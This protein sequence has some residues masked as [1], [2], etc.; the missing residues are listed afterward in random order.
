MARTWSRSLS[1][2]WPPR[3]S[4]SPTRTTASGRAWIPSR[5]ARPWRTC[6][7][8]ASRPGKS[9]GRQHRPEPAPGSPS[10]P[11]LARPR[12]ARAP[13]RCRPEGMMETLQELL[14]ADLSSIADAIG[15]ELAE[16]EGSNLLI[17][18][19]GGFLGYYLVQSV[20]FWNDRRAP[21]RP[22]HVTVVD[23]YR[24]GVPEWLL[25]LRGNRNLALLEHDIS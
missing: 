20:L 8:A 3:A 16:M 23:N 11:H 14:D 5:S 17:T 2:G 1:S 9:G 18:G 13:Y 25:A 4:W 10:R 21:R 12:C 6:T 15:D 19:G 24:R 22:I 7:R